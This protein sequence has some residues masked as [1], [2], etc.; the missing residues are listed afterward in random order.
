MQYDSFETTCVVKMK[1]YW[2]NP[3]TKD[4]TE[5]KK[6]WERQWKEHDVNVTKMLMDAGI[7]IGMDF[8]PI[9][10]IQVIGKKTKSFA[11]IKCYK[12]MSRGARICFGKY[13]MFRDCNMRIEDM[14]LGCKR[15]QNVYH[16]IS[17][18]EMPPTIKAEKC[19]G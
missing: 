13:G 17:L 14:F 4:L 2:P 12:E 15:T 3:T 11:N 10:I 19:D 6:I 1:E 8:D 18:P 9:V 5:N 7:S 16:K